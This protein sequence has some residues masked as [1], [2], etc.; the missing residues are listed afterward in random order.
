MQIGGN[1]ESAAVFVGVDGGI[2]ELVFGSIVGNLLLALILDFEAV[3]CS[4]LDGEDNSPGN[5]YFF[6]HFINLKILIIALK[7]FFRI[8][9]I[10]LRNFRTIYGDKKKNRV[11]LNLMNKMQFHEILVPFKCDS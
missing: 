6:F 10:K 4:G 5:E 11:K 1:F 2:Y 9:G 8:P 3:F 7:F